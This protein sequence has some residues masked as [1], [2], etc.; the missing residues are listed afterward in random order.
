MVNG[1]YYALLTFAFED[2]DF[3]PRAFNLTANVSPDEEG[4]EEMGLLIAARSVDRMSI[5]HNAMEGTGFA[6]I[7]EKT[8]PAAEPWRSEEV[9]R[10]EGV[11]LGSPDAEEVK[12]FVRSIAGG[13]DSFIYP[14]DFR[15]PG[16]V[17]DMVQSGEYGVLTARDPRGG[18]AGG[19]VWRSS[20]TSMIECYGPYVFVEE[21]RAGL[22]ERLV[23][24]LISA[25][26]RSE[27]VCLMNRYATDD[28]PPGYFETLGTIDLALPG[29]KDHGN[30]SSA[31][32]G[33]TPGAGY[34]PTQGWKIS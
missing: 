18:I 14:Q 25:V 13:Y 15:Y 24:G 32:S 29:K 4:L 11:T 17:V 6:L 8:Y 22:A 31:S 26:A 1:F 9:P 2:I 33:K 19:M 23:S 12:V 16:K 27:A 7:K 28:L 10:A 3:D 30:F 20:G 21:G 5:F 34:T